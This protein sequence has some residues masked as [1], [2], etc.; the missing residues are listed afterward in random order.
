MK[1]Y[2]MITDTIEN[3]G[4][5]VFFLIMFVV[6][7]IQVAFRYIFHIP[8]IGA[9]EIARYCMIW[10]IYFG[11]SSCVKDK[12]HIGIDGLVLLLPSPFGQIITALA[13]VIYAGFNVTLFFLAFHLTQNLYGTQQTSPALLLPMWLAYMALPVGFGLSAM[14]SLTSLPRDIIALFKKDNKEGAVSQ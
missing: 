5:F 4:M 11:I 8:F 3:Y 10:G 12:T 7:I 13:L 14:H 9:E 1:V 2:K 6:I